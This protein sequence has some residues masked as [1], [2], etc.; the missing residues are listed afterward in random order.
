TLKG[1]EATSRSDVYY[2]DAASKSDDELTFVKLGTM[3]RQV[4][5]YI[6]NASNKVSFKVLIDKGNESAESSDEVTKVLRKVI[7]LGGNEIYIHMDG[8]NIDM[9][10]EVSASS[11]SMSDI[12]TLGNIPQDTPGGCAYKTF[13]ARATQEI[14]RRFQGEAFVK[15][16]GVYVNIAKAVMMYAPKDKVSSANAYDGNNKDAYD[17]DKY[18]INNY[19]WADMFYDVKEKLDDRKDIQKKLFG[20]DYDELTKWT[21]A[22]GD[23]MLFVPPTNINV[24]ESV[25]NETMPILRAKG[26]MTKGGHRVTRKLAMSVYFNEE[27][28][29]NGVAYEVEVGKDKK[30]PTKITYYMNGLRQLIAQFKFTPFLPIE[31]EYINETLGIYAILFDTIQISHVPNYPHLYKAE[32][33]MSEFDY[34]TYMPEIAVMAEE[35]GLEDY[36]NPFSAS[37]NWA[38]MRYYYQRCIM[39]GEDIALSGYHFNSDEYRQLIIGNRT[40]LVPMAFKSNKMKLYIGDREQMDKMLEARMKQLS[41][42]NEEK[43]AEL[44]DAELAQMDKFKSLNNE[45]QRVIMSP[46]CQEAI[47]GISINDDNSH[48]MEFKGNLFSDG[49]TVSNKKGAIEDK[50]QALSEIFNSDLKDAVNSNCADGD[51]VADIS[52]SELKYEKVSDGYDISFDVEFLVGTDYLSGEENLKDIKKDAGICMKM[53]P[54][55]FYNDNKICVT[56]SAHF[57]DGTTTDNDENL[58]SYTRAQNQSKKKSCVCDKPFAI[59]ADSPDM[60]FLDFCSNGKKHKEQQEKKKNDLRSIADLDNL[61]YVEYALGDYW[62]KDFNAMLSN[63]VSSVCINNI[64]GT[65]AQY[66]GGEDTKFSLYI[67]TTDQETVRALVELP[68]MVAR[69][70]RDYHIILPYYPLRI[71][72]ELTAFMGINEVV[73][74]NCSASTEADATGVYNIQMELRSVDRT[75]RDRE[76]MERTAINNGGLLDGS[77]GTKTNKKVAS[78]SDIKKLLAKAEL[79]PDL[80]LPTVKELEEAG[81]DYVRYKFQFDRTYVDPDFYFVYP[82]VL[83]SQCVREL[84]L[85]GMANG[86]GDSVLTDKAGASINITPTPGQGF[87]ITEQ[88]EK[89]KEQIEKI[90][91]E[92]EKINAQDQK[93]THDNAKKKAFKKNNNLI[94]HGNLEQWSICD[95]IT[96]QFLEQDYKDQLISYETNENQQTANQEGKWVSD[97]REKVVK[98]SEDIIEYLKTHE[99]HASPCV[100]G[101]VPNFELSPSEIKTSIL[102]AV[103]NF[104]GRDE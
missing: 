76:A 66:L 32:I 18:D 91:A 33:I 11:V 104:L 49:G 17:I 68:K 58:D 38:V 103:T 80:E 96:P 65:A 13:F 87:T 23:V 9:N 19:F 55:K 70:A 20:L 48:Y 29:I 24:I 93:N 26:T 83:L 52:V 50:V 78:Y 21:V 59:I 63:H 99:L 46:E 1:T 3:Y 92:R 42:K 62:I 79:Y 72:S 101:G 75:L 41:G 97:A 15:I 77:E 60:K 69:M 45:I 37:I 89:Y 95:D 28:G 102:T 94:L 2:T 71:E 30:N 43:V 56:Y 31:N 100:K 25:N 54:S 47:N 39:R 44:T 88:N 36:G 16:D 64:S 61:K 84:C 81:F 4:K 5:N 53:N 35:K 51:L 10:S 40:S 22:I 34:E 14:D 98:A 27:R 7:E 86:M 57:K 6:E 82:Q 85:N 12:T 74:E 8:K 73:I 67:E 90:K